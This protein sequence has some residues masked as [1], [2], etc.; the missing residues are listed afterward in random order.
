MPVP[1]EGA[2]PI[3]VDSGIQNSSPLFTTGMLYRDPANGDQYF[4]A[5]SIQTE[6]A[7]DKPNDLESAKPKVIDWNWRDWTHT[8]VSP[9]HEHG[10]GEDT[11]VA[12]T[13][14]SIILGHRDFATSL[15]ATRRNLGEPGSLMLDSDWVGVAKD[16][17]LKAQTALLIATHIVNEYCQPNSDAK[18]TR[19]KLAKLD[20]YKLVVRSHGGRGRGLADVMRDLQES[21]IRSKAPSGS[22]QASV[23]AL[24]KMSTKLIFFQVANEPEGLNI[25][26]FGLDAVVPLAN[27]IDRHRLTRTFK[28]RHNNGPPEIYPV[29]AAAQALLVEMAKGDLGH[30]QVSRKE[31]LG[32]YRAKKRNEVDRWLMANLTEKYHGRLMANDLTWQALADVHTDLLRPALL[33]IRAKG[34]DDYIPLQYIETSKLARAKKRALLT[35]ATETDNFAQARSALYAVHA[36]NRDAYDKLLL[37]FLA[38]VPNHFDVEYAQISSFAVGTDNPEVWQALS[39]V[40]LKANPAMCLCLLNGL[41]V[42]YEALEPQVFKRNAVPLLVPYFDDKRKVADNPDIDRALGPFGNF[43]GDLPSIGRVALRSAAFAAGIYRYNMPELNEEGWASLRKKIESGD[44]SPLP[45][46]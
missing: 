43:D 4:V 42:T 45:D 1:P 39:A 2:V 41:A 10:F 27:E 32:W 20:H 18:V 23:D 31:A 19:E 12:T 28:P 37:K 14:Q 25:M 21:D 40:I 22:P 26:R 33:A 6:L 17:S 16:E 34:V 11:T 15:I 46:K 24:L 9:F 30:W 35:E 29:R 44:F 8:L 38:K 13:V 3:L 5:G 7:S 36:L